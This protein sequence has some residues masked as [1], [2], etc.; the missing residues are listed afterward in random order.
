M[1]TSGYGRSLTMNTFENYE[2]ALGVWDAA[3]EFEMDDEVE[4]SN[5]EALC[6]EAVAE[7][8]ARRRLQLE[9]LSERLDTFKNPLRR[10]A[11][12][13][14][15]ALL[16]HGRWKFIV[17]NGA[18]RVYDD[19]LGY[20]RAFSD[21][22][23][24]SFRKFLNKVAPIYWIE[25]YQSGLA[26]QVYAY[27]VDNMDEFGYKPKAKH[28]AIKPGDYINFRNGIFNIA[29][30]E[31]NKHSPRYRALTVVDADF[32]DGE[33]TL[34]NKVQEFFNHLGGDA[35]G[36]KALM[37]IGGLAISPSRNLQ[38]GAFLIGEGGSGKGVF[39]EILRNLIPRESVISFSLEG[40]SQRFALKGLESAQIA[41]CSELNL[42]Q[43][44]T[45]DIR[46]L[47][48]MISGDKI[49][50]EKKYKDPQEVYPQ[51][52]VICCGN[53]F[54][55]GIID[56]SGAMERRIMLVKTGP[57]VKTRNPQ[58]LTELMLYKP[59]IATAFARA[60]SAVYNGE[61]LLS[62]ELPTVSVGVM[63]KRSQLAESWLRA[64]VTPDE[65]GVFNISD[66]FQRFVE[67][68]EGDPQM[69]NRAFGVI[70]A[71]MLG[72]TKE[73]LADGSYVRYGW[74][75]VE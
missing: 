52:M 12:E 6:E 19:N 9:E 51:A 37:Q 1:C 27:I 60:A 22:G 49:V 7:F 53:A 8:E 21:S 58:L 57:T 68:A 39:T 43:A 11:F 73:R 29:T 61:P 17:V 42:G 72:G 64:H 66:A 62:H 3:P 40:L 18:L 71:K 65:N 16:K 36:V 75:F 34:P 67:S 50:L 33:M 70:V 4:T 55:Q 47:K 25:L 56:G 59:Y 26:E 24:L 31:F 46:V 44:N 69:D 2:K 45:A 14:I 5:F 28:E 38:T 32:L 10:K 48:S 15:L 30:G 23:D 41:I 13:V 20:F 54:P 63:K 74:R 35:D